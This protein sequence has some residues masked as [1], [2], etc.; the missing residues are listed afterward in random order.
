MSFAAIAIAASATTAIV[1]AVGAIRAGKAEQK[2]EEYNARIAENQAEIE[3]LEMVEQAKRAREK[4]KAFLG[5]QLA[6]R[7]A[8]GLDVQS[9]SSLLMQAETAGRLEME[10][11]ENNRLR[12]NRAMRQ[13]SEASMAQFRGRQ[14][15]KAAGFKAGESL[16]RGA[17]NVASGIKQNFKDDA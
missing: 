11:F 15:R 5:H 4:N 1:G 14:A 3:E 2:A 16:L 13:R 9:G 10:V 8:G 7:S 6:R 12:Q 17:A